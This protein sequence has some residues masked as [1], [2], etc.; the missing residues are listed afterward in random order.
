MGFAAGRFVG[1]GTE[2]FGHDGIGNHADGERVKRGAENGVFF[3]GVRDAD[4]MI[5]IAERKL[6]QL[7]G[8]YARRICKS[9]KRVICKHRP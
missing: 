4:D 1:E 8:Q 5:N 7:I 2:I 6:Q 3:A 9:E